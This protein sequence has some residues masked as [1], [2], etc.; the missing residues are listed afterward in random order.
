MVINEFD[1]QVDRAPGVP[2]PSM[3][4]YVEAYVKTSEKLDRAE[5]IIKL[6]LDGDPYQHHV[7][8]S[9]EC[10]LCHGVQSD[11][12]D[13]CPWWLANHYINGIWSGFQPEH[14]FQTQKG[15]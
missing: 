13:D 12:F 10:K 11:H 9:P 5:A 6:L 3:S 7:K 14:T 15:H 4:D 8:F 1:P 2:G